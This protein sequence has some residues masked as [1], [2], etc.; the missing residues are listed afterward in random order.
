MEHLAGSQVDQVAVPAA[1]QIADVLARGADAC[2]P[3]S[4]SLAARA[5]RVVRRAE[6]GDGTRSH[7]RVIGQRRPQEPGHARERWLILTLIHGWSPD[8]ERARPRAV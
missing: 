5:G 4:R 7:V 1:E 3:E 6:N 8:G 2:R